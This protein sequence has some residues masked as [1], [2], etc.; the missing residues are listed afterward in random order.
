MRSHLSSKMVGASIMVTNTE[1][2]I[3]ADL[4]RALVQEN[5]T[6][7]IAQHIADKKVIEERMDYH[8][9]FCMELFV[10]TPDELHQLIQEEVME[11]ERF[12]NFSTMYES[13]N[14]EQE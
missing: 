3:N 14:K 6:R 12:M 9:A 5:L 13:I 2:N 11:R 1:M 4:Q 8:T 7:M 10:L